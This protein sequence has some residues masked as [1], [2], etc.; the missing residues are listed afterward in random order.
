M[1]TTPHVPSLNAGSLSWLFSLAVLLWLPARIAPAAEPSSNGNQPYI[2]SIHL[3]GTN[4]VVVA[5]VPANVQRVTLE[6]RQRVKEGAW[7][8]RAVNRVGGKS[9]ELTFR[10]PQS[11]KIE[12][13]RLRTDSQ[14][15]LPDSFYTNKSVFAGAPGSGG[16]PVDGR[17]FDAAP[18]GATAGGTETTTVRDVVESDIWKVSGDFVYFF[19]QYRGLQIINHSQPDAPVLTGTFSLPAAGEQMYLMNGNIVVLLA[20]QNCYGPSDSNSGQ[21]ILLRNDNG[22]PVPIASLPVP[23]FIDESRLVGTALYIASEYYR[24]VTSPRSD[25]W[26]WGT[27][28]SSYD[29][30]DPEHPVARST[31]WYSGYGNIVTATEDF[32][33]V[34]SQ[35]PDNWQ[36][37]VVRCLDISDPT[38]VMSLFATVHPSGRVTDKFKMNFDRNI[39]TVISET[40]TPAG[41]LI[42]TLEN[43]SLQVRDVPVT[44]GS[45]Q[46]GERE[47]LHATRFDGDRVYVVTFFQID[48]LWIVDLSDPA[49][50]RIAGSVEV[51]GWSSYIQPLGD[52]LLTVG[53]ESHRVA[54]SLFGVADP[55]SPKLLSRV[56]LGETYSWSEATSDEKAFSYLPDQG[57]ILV[58]Y[59]GDTTNG[60]V[61]RVQ[62]IDLN[63]DTLTQRGLIE[64]PFQPRRATVHQNRI[65]SISGWELL[66]VDASNRDKPLVTAETELAW[67]VN[68]VVAKGDFIV[69]VDN[70]NGWWWGPVKPSLRVAA[71]ADPNIVRAQIFLAKSDPIQGLSVRGDRLYIAQEPQ[72]QFYYPWILAA[73]GKTEPDTNVPPHILTVSI[74]DLS[75]LPALPL[76]GRTEAPVDSV[77]W[78]GDLQAVWPTDGVQVWAARGGYFWPIWGMATDVAVGGAIAIRPGFFRPWW[79]GNAERLSAV[80]VSDAA[81]PKLVS[82]ITLSESNRWSFSSP[83][84]A[85]GKV[86]L[87]FQ[88]SEFVTNPA[89]AGTVTGSGTTPDG[90]PIVVE[91]N[92]EPV[93]VWVQKYFLDVVDYADAQ[94][95]T[96]RAPVNVPG[97]LNGV[98]SDGELLY[99]TGYHWDTAQNTDWT[100]WLD[101]SAYDGIAAHLVDSL[102]LRSWPHPLTLAGPDI[103]I[104][105]A[106]PSNSVPNLLGTWTLDQTGHFTRLSSQELKVAAQDLFLTGNLLVVVSDRLQ[107]FN[108]SD[109]ASLKLI[110]ENKSAYCWGYDLR[111]GDGSVDSGFWLPMGIYGATKISLSP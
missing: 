27:M 59:Q 2:R 73:D 28:V 10:L 16:V 17:V 69:E 31:L 75:Q 62:L 4:V 56:L 85:A 1:K 52:R 32:L 5:W 63:N 81:A 110:G 86:Y 88:T 45:L 11:S 13:I 44:L 101:A 104:G 47:R 51:P 38:G 109:P 43:F 80:D 42:T 89:P 93:G 40:Q 84:A 91:T 33:F 74:Y 64:H 21:V 53:V 34:A 20:R 36:K 76:L 57:L 49:H 103:L 102:P 26:E 3:E 39:F 25:T 100:E 90:K 12:L 98:S 68:R 106:S 66:V 95:P 23:G 7:Q 19:N 9:G 8:P 67:D 77:G 72:G 18:G 54:V 70:G 22:K 79:G 50:P 58:P 15:P 82:S 78:N 29:L 71:A 41:R 108:A 65:L 55:A 96:V 105:E 46:L 111:N 6:S 24:P 14:E 30:K 60:Y 37:S 61:S 94:H 48:P 35:M 97:T 107:L 83:F 99:T 87:S 92:V